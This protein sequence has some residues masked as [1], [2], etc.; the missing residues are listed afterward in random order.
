MQWFFL[1]PL[2]P[3]GLRN[4]FRQW[5]IFSDGLRRFLLRIIAP[6]FDLLPILV[7]FLRFVGFA[8]RRCAGRRALEL[9]DLD[10]HRSI[11]VTGRDIHSEKVVEPAIGFGEAFDQWR[12]HPPG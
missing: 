2:P 12:S 5:P 9:N 1:H 3:Y 11:A 6:T 7:N 4:A 8:S 10:S